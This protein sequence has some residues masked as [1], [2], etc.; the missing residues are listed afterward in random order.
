MTKEGEYVKFKNY[1]GKIK[2]PI[3]IYAESD[4]TLVPKENEKQNPGES[5][6]KKYQ[7]HIACS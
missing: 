1:E 3:M 4:S 5:Y 7:K 6:T 2:S